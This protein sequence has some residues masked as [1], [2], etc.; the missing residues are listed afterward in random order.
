MKR[1]Q[2]RNDLLA[3]II[4][5]F[6]LIAISAPANSQKVVLDNDFSKIEKIEDRNMEYLE[7]L[8]K[9]TKK[10]PLFSYRYEMQN[11]E[12]KN[13]TVTGVDYMPDVEK[14]RIKLLD[15]QSNKNQLKHTPSRI[16]VFYAVDKNAYYKDGKEALKNTLHEH[17]KYPVDAKNWG[18]E[19]TIYVRFV[20]DDKGKI[21]FASTTDNIDTEIKQYEDD[22]KKQAVS[23]IKATSGDWEPGKV[24]GVSVA[25]FH[26]IP[27]T[28][29]LEKS[30]FIPMMIH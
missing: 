23:A 21:P 27:I 18:V 30:P 28:F 19:G 22:L 26:I 9:I 4:S 13:V 10:Y 7:D 11:G 5:I 25:S 1:P 16:G 2:I 20:I 15:L 14:I 8:Y 24:N 29:E 6:S 17:L 12:I 3:P